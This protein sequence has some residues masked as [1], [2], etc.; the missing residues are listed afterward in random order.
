[1]TNTSNPASKGKSTTENNYILGQKGKHLRVVFLLCEKEDNSPYS[2]RKPP[3]LDKLKHENQILVTIT[4]R[5]YPEQL[6]TSVD[7][8]KSKQSNTG[9][10]QVSE[11]NSTDLGQGNLLKKGLVSSNFTAEKIENSKMLKSQKSL[12]MP[13]T[14]KNPERMKSNSEFRRPQHLSS[15]KLENSEKLKIEKSGDKRAPE[16]H[17]RKYKFEYGKKKKNRKLELT[18]IEHYFMDTEDLLCY[19][20]LNWM[21][22]GIEDRIASSYNCF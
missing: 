18:M 22:V 12:T 7:S 17:V 6:A 11:L 4:E 16:Y 3:I 10:V 2:I 13:S 19:I 20:V 9:S 21:K 1:M 15:N 8:K 14:V 5:T